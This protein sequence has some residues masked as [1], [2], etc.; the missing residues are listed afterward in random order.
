MIPITNEDLSAIVV[1]YESRDMD[2][3]NGI[4]SKLGGRQSVVNRLRAVLSN[5]RFHEKRFPIAPGSPVLQESAS[6]AAAVPKL[7][8]GTDLS[9][10][11]AMRRNEALVLLSSCKSKKYPEFLEQ[12]SPDKFASLSDSEVDLWFGRACDEFRRIR[13]VDP[14]VSSKPIS[15]GGSA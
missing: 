3:V 13:G 9:K 2:S 15:N 14:P 1:G 5:V 4:V 8:A 7:V 12:A 10:L 6:Q 11:R